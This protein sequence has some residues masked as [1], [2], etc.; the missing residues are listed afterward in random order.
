[1]AVQFRDKPALKRFEMK[2]WENLTMQLGKSLKQE[3]QLMSM[4]TYDQAE[5]PTRQI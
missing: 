5:Q 4:K 1:M 2:Y 3:K